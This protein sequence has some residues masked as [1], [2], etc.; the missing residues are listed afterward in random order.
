MRRS[1][2]TSADAAPPSDA[3]A[4]GGP[5][6]AC[7]WLRPPPTSNT[8][9]AAHSAATYGVSRTQLVEARRPQPAT[10]T[11]PPPTARPYGVSRTQLV[12]AR[13]RQPVTRTPPPPTARPYGVSRT[14]L[15]EARRRQ[16]VTRTP[17]PPT[18]RPYGVSRTQLVEARPPPTSN[19]HSAATHRAS[20]R[21]VAYPLARPA[22]RSANWSQRSG[23]EGAATPSRPA[24][25][26][27]KARPG[28][29]R[30]GRARG[31]DWWFS[32]ASSGLRRGP[33]PRRCSRTT[34]D[35]WRRTRRTGRSRPAGP[36]APSG[37]PCRSP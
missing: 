29:V 4:R 25:R 10:R 37:C 5:R 21:R 3:G 32:Q 36:L 24:G 35:H 26:K 23:R 27:G 16:P 33:G 17:P 1:T 12:E 2:R 15:V 11:P 14:Q 7:P 30:R 31:R 6:W 28:D 8:H 9:S 13:R 20:L 19:T 22:I 18:A 34:G